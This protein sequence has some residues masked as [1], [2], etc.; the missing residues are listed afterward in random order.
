MQAQKGGR[1]VAIAIALLIVYNTFSRAQPKNGSV[2]EA[3][4]CHC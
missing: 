1:I 4:T 2:R 3:E